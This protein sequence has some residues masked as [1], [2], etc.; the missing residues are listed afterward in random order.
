MASVTLRGKTQH[1][2][3]ELPQ[4]GDSAPDFLLTT[5]SLKDIS[6]A[7]FPGIK[8]LLYIVPS[9]DT[10]VC[11]NTTV[12]LEEKM[13]DFPGAKALVISADLPFAMGRFCGA[14]K[15]KNVLPLSIFRAK[16]FAE[17]Y[18]V[19]LIDGP[20]AGLTA[21]AV[22]VID[23]QDTVVYSHLVEEI[24]DEPDFESALRFLA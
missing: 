18:G 14:K 2:S 22:L 5:S 19:L 13:R 21:R 12:A 11:A 7:K 15:F 24:S 8:K 23:E 3:A 20:L 16:E 1:T 4:V 10:P 9:L 6:L 17:D